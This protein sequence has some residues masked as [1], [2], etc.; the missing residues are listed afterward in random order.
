MGSQNE[1][2]KH[3]FKVGQGFE[4]GAFGLVTRRRPSVGLRQCQA[5]PPE[6]CF[7]ASNPGRAVPAQSSGSC[8]PRSFA[9]S[10]PKQPLSP[11]W[12]HP[13]C[14]QTQTRRAC[15]AASGAEGMRTRLCS[16]SRT[17]LPRTFCGDFAARSNHRRLGEES[18]PR[19]ERAVRREAGESI[20]GRRFGRLGGG[21]VTVGLGSG[22]E[23]RLRARLGVGP[24]GS[25]STVAPTV[26]PQ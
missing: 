16:A 17:P 15:W 6:R 10:N 22:R 4:R 5:P 19:S 18:P 26:Q 25:Y 3:S 7:P 1:L 11:P 13:C 21:V 12:L 2:R 9:P 24:Q 20:F 23:R 14:E 8:P